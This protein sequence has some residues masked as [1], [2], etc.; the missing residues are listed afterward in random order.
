MR[1]LF[2]AALFATCLVG[3]V[4]SAEDELPPQLREGR[5]LFVTHC[6][7]CH[8]MH[9]AGG[10]G[11]NLRR[12]KLR[13][14]ANEQDL[15]LVIKAG[16]GGTGM[17]GNWFI[18]DDEIRQLIPYVRSLG[19]VAQEPLT[20]NPSKGKLLYDKHDCAKCHMIQR[21]G[22]TLGPDLTNIGQ[23][24]GPEFFRR[25]V[26][27]PGDELP[28]DAN[29]YPMY[30]VVLAI[31]EDGRLISGTRLNEDSF[32]IQLRDGDN[33]LVSLRK[34]DLEAL[35]KT[36]GSIM[37]NYAEQLSQTDIEDLVS[38]LAKLEEEL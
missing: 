22:G 30:L 16:I 10:T 32:T 31:T 14:A 24:R 20:G 2:T 6:A 23:K 35:K 33:R 28:E 5:R 36:G 29:G 27:H 26:L 3:R 18:S 8:G 25:A 21:K 15:Y 7:R 19:K 37:P 12:P 17:P 13:R 38:W 1:F 34:A 4:R 11:A 9:G